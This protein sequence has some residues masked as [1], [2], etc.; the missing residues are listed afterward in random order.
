MTAEQVDRC[1]VRC[2]KCGAWRLADLACRTCLAWHI[3]A[4]R[5]EH[6]AQQLDE[7]PA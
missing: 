1:V 5:A 2:P 4:L 3:N 7:Q 6:A